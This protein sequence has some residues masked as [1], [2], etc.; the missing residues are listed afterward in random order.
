MLKVDISR[1]N[2]QQTVQAAGSIPEVMN[3]VAVLL[4]S[5]YNQFNAVSPAAAK[6][7]RKGIENMLRD[8]KGEV[9]KAAG[10]QTGIIFRKPDEEV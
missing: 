6:L 1:E 2:K 5:I 4:S 10:S 3:D 8:P 9:W 7:F